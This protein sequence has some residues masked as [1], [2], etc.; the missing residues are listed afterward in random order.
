MTTPDSLAG[1]LTLLEAR[2]PRAIEL[3]LERVES[4]RAELG[5]TLSCPVITV[6]GTNG[7]G[8]A[9]AYLEAMLAEAGYRVGCY[10]SPHLL[11]YNERVRIDRSECTDADLTAAFAAVEAARGEVPLTYFEHGTL[12]AA[13][14]F[15]RAQVQAAILEVGL[16]GRLDAV[17][18]FDADC[19]VVTSVDLDHQEYLGETREA[20]GFE[21]AG[22]FRRGRPAVVTDPAPPASLLAHARTIGAELLRL[23][24]E[25][26]LEAN[27]DSWSCRVL[28]RIYPALPRPSLAGR[29]QLDNAAAAVA[30][31]ACLHDR[32]PVPI[33]A[34]RAGLVEALPAGRFQVLPGTPRIVLDVAHNPHAARALAATL[35]ALRGRGQVHAVLGMLR[36]KDVAGVVRAIAPLASSWHTAG[37]PGPRGLSGGELAELVQRHAGCRPRMHDNIAEALSIACAD[38]EPADIITVFGSFYTVA[39]A[40][41]AL[42]TKTA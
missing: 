31:L 3:G 34:M 10:T 18:V 28:D 21:K 14:L 23:G 32:L 29:H 19:A 26:R 20:I 37:L 17:N 5:L 1:W 11:R 7:K 8:S 27:G 22:I 25:I 42:S 6:G 38:A 16:G 15:A 13:W 2:H 33:R 9:C 41:R 39:E 4:V 24:D 40:L 36:D 30:A 35:T 12:A